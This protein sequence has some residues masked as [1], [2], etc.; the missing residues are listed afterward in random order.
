MNFYT[1]PDLYDIK[2][3][4]YVPYKFIIFTIYLN[5]SVPKFI[6]LFPAVAKVHATLP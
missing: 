5:I 4:F 3:Q 6:Q 2:I 1:P